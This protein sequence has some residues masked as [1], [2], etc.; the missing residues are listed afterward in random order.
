MPVDSVRAQI[1]RPMLRRVL[2]YW[3]ARRGTRA[4]PSRAAVDPLQLGFALG[5]LLLIDVLRDPLQFRYRLV[6]TVAAERWGF[7][8]TGKTLD[9]LPAPERRHFILQN[10]SWIV[11]NRRPMAIEGTRILDGRNW[12]FAS[13]MLPIGEDDRQVDMILVCVEYTTP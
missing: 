3:E 11:E 9:E 1:R 4:F 12:A 8:M 10:Y 7:D 6:G 13:L 2:D 5:N